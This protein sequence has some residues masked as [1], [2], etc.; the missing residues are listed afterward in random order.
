MKK[1]SNVI[2]IEESS[3]SNDYMPAS[4]INYRITYDG[5]NIEYY[6][7]NVLIQITEK[8]TRTKLACLSKVFNI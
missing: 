8:L 4:F 6:I 2:S 5:T 1:N 7:N 3:H